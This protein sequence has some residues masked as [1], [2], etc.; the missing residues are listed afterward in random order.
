MN[1]TRKALHKFARRIEDART[2][3]WTTVGNMS[4]HPALKRTPSVCNCF[5]RRFTI[6]HAAWQV[7]KSREKTTTFF[8]G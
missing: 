1:A 8:S 4:I 5:F 7:W 3:H 6:C 2:R